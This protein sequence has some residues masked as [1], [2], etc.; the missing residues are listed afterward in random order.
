MGCV[1]CA[2]RNRAL[3]NS[4]CG[5]RLQQIEAL[6]IRMRTLFN[7]TTTDNVKRTEYR[8]VLS[9]IDAIILNSK[10]VCPT[11]E[12]INLLTNYINNEYIADN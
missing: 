4:N 1:P 8:S 3:R 11:Q 2:K 6:R 5:G 12:D 9:D 7:I 10:T